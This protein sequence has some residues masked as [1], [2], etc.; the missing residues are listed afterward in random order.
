MKN[1]FTFSVLLG[2]ALIL[3][4]GCGIGNK[5]P[6]YVWNMKDIIGLWFFGIIVVVL[7]VAWCYDEINAWK[8]KR[9]NKNKTN[10]HRN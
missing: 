2:T 10:K 8:A 6:I 7:I 4:S 3:T 1:K 9:R 5:E